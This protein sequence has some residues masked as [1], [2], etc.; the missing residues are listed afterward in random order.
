MPSRHWRYGPPEWWREGH[1]PPPWQHGGAAWRGFRKRIFIGF[2]LFMLFVIGVLALV[3]VLLA[4]LFRTAAAVI[5]TPVIIGVV[6]LLGL[7]WAFRTWGPIR[8]LIGAAGSLADGDYATRV[9]VQGSPA[10]RRVGASLNEMAERLEEAET[11]RRRLLADLGHELRTP[12]TVIRGEVEAM[13][14]GVHQPD[15]RHLELLI[16]EVEVMERLLEDLRTLSLAEAGTLALHPEPTDLNVLVADVADGYRRVAGEDG[17]EVIVQL[18]ERIPEAEIDPVRI[19]EVVTN[20][21]VN[22]LRAMPDGGTLTLTLTTLAGR[23]AVTIEVADTGHGIDPD[24]LPKVFDRFHRSPGSPGSGLGLTISRDLVRS[25]GG[26]LTL[27]SRPGEGTVA[28]VTLPA[29]R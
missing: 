11:Q 17:V 26:T 20:L 28:T 27:D 3:G 2:V 10:V 24:E 5:T 9:P 22:A 8:E 19:R 13:L 7:R 12:L 1:G 15:P 23:E 29:G 25:H 18:D 16:D 6:A 14:D 4:A 21:V